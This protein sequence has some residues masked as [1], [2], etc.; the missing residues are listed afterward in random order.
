MPYDK[1]ETLKMLD[2]LLDLD[3]GLQSREIEQLE[4]IEILRDEDAYLESYAKWL[5]DL[6]NR[7]F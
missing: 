5:E 3:R 2:D 7:H 1:K 4:T 6:W